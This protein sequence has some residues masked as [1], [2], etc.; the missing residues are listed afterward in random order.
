METE[1]ELQSRNLSGHSRQ[2]LSVLSG[3]EVIEERQECPPEDQNRQKVVRFYGRKRPSQAARLRDIPEKRIKM[4][5]DDGKEELEEEEKQDEV[6]KA[7][8]RAAFLSVFVEYLQ[9]TDAGSMTEEEAKV[10][11]TQVG[12]VMDSID[13]DMEDG[14]T[15]HCLLDRG[16]VSK[17]IQPS[18]GKKRS[19][20]IFRKRL[21]SLEKFYVFLGCQ[22][23]PLQLARSLSSTISNWTENV[24]ELAAFIHTHPVSGAQMVV[25]ETSTA[26]T[27]VTG[28]QTCT[29]TNLAAGIPSSNESCDSYRERK[30]WKSEDSK[31]IKNHFRTNPGKANIRLKMK[32]KKELQGLL[33]REGFD[34]IYEKVKSVF[35]KK[36]KKLNKQSKQRVAWKRQDVL[37]LLNHFKGNPGKAA[38]RRKLHSAE[39]LRE[40]TN[41]EGLNRIYEKVKSLFKRKKLAVC[42][43]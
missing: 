39:A 32:R 35:R 19:M 30:A 38:V 11:A 27:N 36:V 5:R 22:G 6:L 41:R 15:I 28:T 23:F 24:N 42:H 37:I 43:S 33:N 34:R 20:R 12:D 29:R 14:D 7:A 8:T 17:W 13:C 2:T 21:F 18:A 9:T 16:R 10:H 40:L 1:Q 4:E 31:L 3:N 26:S 25:K